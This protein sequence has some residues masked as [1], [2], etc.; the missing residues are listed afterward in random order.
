LEKVG[1]KFN[2]TVNISPNINNIKKCILT[3]Y[4]TQVAILQKN[5]AY[6]TIKESQIVA[7]HPSSVLS[8]K[9][10]LVLYNEL[11]LTKKNYIRTIL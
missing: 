7:I 3:G 9:P 2:D 4:F 8:Y 1:V 5:N 11:V 10:E 6:L